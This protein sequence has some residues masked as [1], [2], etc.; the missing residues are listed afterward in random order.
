MTVRLQIHLRIWIYF[1]EFGWV[2]CR[3]TLAF[4]VVVRCG[5]TCH[6]C[7]CNFVEAA[8]EDIDDFNRKGGLKAVGDAL[9]RGMVLVMS[10]WDDAEPWPHRR[11]H[12]HTCLLVTRR[13]CSLEF[14]LESVFPVMSICLSFFQFLPRTRWLWCHPSS[15]HQ[16]PLLATSLSLELPQFDFLVWQSGSFS[17]LRRAIDCETAW[18]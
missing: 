14:V 18:W 6:F 17:S 9:D 7:V 15:S 2:V 12:T 1:D 10:L 8:F 5:A 4:L 3:Y 13:L 16:A 11:Y